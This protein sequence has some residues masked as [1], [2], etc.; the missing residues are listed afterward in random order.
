[1]GIF[2]VFAVCT[3]QINAL[4]DKNKELNGMPDEPVHDKNKELNDMPEEPL[5][6]LELAEMNSDT[7]RVANDM[8]FVIDN[9]SADIMNNEEA[10]D[11][12]ILNLDEEL[13]MN[14]KMNE[15][16]SEQHVKQEE[17]AMNDDVTDDPHGM[18]DLTNLNEIKVQEEKMNQ[19]VK[20]GVDMVDEFFDAEEL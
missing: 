17:D 5:D 16:I 6:E 15:D 12:D 10:G 18:T 9:S 14:E 2:F 19:E 7:Y 3:F 20:D 4:E 11:K 13:N 1:M 8:Q